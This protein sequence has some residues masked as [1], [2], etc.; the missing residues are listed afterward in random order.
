MR[1]LVRVGAFARG[2]SVSTIRQPRLLLML[3]LG[4][5]LVLFLFGIGY[6]ATLPPLQTLVVGADDDPLTARVDDFLR[7]EQ[8]ASLDYQGTSAD[9]DQAVRD[10]EAGAVDLVIVLPDDAMGALEASEQAVIEVHHRSLDPVTFEQIRVASDIAVSQINDEVLRQV[11]VVAQERTAEV[12]DELALAREQLQA[13]RTN[14]D[15]GDIEAA[16]RTAADLAPQIAGLA[17]LLES[18]GGLRGLVGLLGGPDDLADTLRT[19][20]D[21]LEQL[22]RIDGIAQLDQAGT[23]LD[24]LDGVIAQVQAID[25]AIAVAP[26]DASIEAQTPVD[27]TLDRYFAPGVLALM[28][29]HLGITF[30]A[31]A[32]VR[33]RR[34]G[35]LEVLRVSPATM[36]E[37]LAGKTVAFLLLGAIAAVGLTA[38]IV[39][40]FGV[41][42]PIQWL[43]FAGLLAM[44][45]IAAIG[46]GFLVAA[47]SSTD[48]QAVQLSMLLLLTTIFFSGLFMPLDRIG[49]PMKWI[50][51]LLPATHGFLGLQD[52]MLLQQPTHIGLFGAL[53]AIAVVTF[54]AAR[55][56]LPRR[57]E[58]R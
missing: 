11:L 7:A 15:D 5:F 9:R 21:Q 42:L 35:T 18:G 31:L 19:A 3:V 8:P 52:L 37:R 4:P 28:L 48:S 43:T 25:P 10:L 29:Q 58:A 36:G 47:A 45:L 30:A 24:E 56:L 32:L 22:A 20:A 53:L 55:L 16:Q 51:Y 14:V 34:A 13:L 12:D 54:A 33:E 46:I 23:T 6:D 40:V 44:T 38:L 50:S 39:A 41:P 17:D 2:E 1:S 26:F 27:I 57:T 49:F